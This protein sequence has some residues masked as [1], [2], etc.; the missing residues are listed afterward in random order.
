MS[1]QDPL[2]RARKVQEVREVLVDVIVHPL[3]RFLDLFFA[4]DVVGD[5]DDL[6]LVFLP[7][8]GVLGQKV[9][10]GVIVFDSNCG[11]HVIEILAFLL[12]KRDLFG[13]MAKSV[14]EK[15]V[16]FLLVWLK[17]VIVEAVGEFFL[18]HKAII[19]SRGQWIPLF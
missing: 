15:L 10:F 1:D 18:A 14:E 7:P 8:N 4:I 16:S 6:V 12:G 13:H 2:V 5:D 9:E 11:A 3:G 17:R 19:R